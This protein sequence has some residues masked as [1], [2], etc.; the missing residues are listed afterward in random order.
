MERKPGEYRRESMCGIIAVFGLADS[1]IRVRNRLL[2]LSK[3]L[4]HRGPD[5]SGIHQEKK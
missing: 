2:D 5:W 3:R 1:S 4:R